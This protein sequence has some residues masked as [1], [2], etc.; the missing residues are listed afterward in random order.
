[1]P[2]EEREKERGLLLIK[3]PFTSVRLAGIL[4]EGIVLEG[5]GAPKRQQ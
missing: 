1:M 4:M 2:G 3:L 5:G